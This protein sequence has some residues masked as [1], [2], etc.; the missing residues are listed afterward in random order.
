MPCQFAF[1]VMSFQQ[2]M[3]PIY[4]NAIAPAVGSFGIECR[5]VDKTHFIT[6]RITDRILSDIRHSYFVIADL[7]NERPNCYY[8]LGFAH[9]LAKPVILLINDT[10]KIPFDVKDFKFIV[11][12]D[13]AE[14]QRQLTECIHETI[15]KNHD[16]ES[17]SDP[18]CGQFGRYAFRNGRLL[19]AILTPIDGE[20]LCDVTLVVT[21]TPGSPPLNGQARFYVHPTYENAAARTVPVREGVA[22]YKIHDADE[23]FTVGAKIDDDKTFLELNLRSIPGSF[24][25]FYTKS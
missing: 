16:M 2:E 17:E 18:R 24:P 13:P 14:L 21:S 20:D 12:S 1:T 3:E 4:S 11:Y 15:L 25:S 7:S 6:D 19:S 9:A 10:K 23:Y 5:R 22:K 8:E